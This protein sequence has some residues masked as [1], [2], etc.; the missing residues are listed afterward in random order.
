ME[1]LS[2]LGNED[3]AGGIGG[4]EPM[5]PGRL[6]AAASSAE[7]A[8]GDNALLWDRGVSETLLMLLLAPP[9]LPAVASSSLIA[10]GA[11]KGREDGKGEGLAAACTP[12]IAPGGAEAL[13]AE[14]AEGR[15]ALDPPLWLPAAAETALGA[16]AAA[17]FPA[18]KAL[19]AADVD[20]EADASAG[21]GSLAD[22]RPGLASCCRSE[23]SRFCREGFMLAPARAAACRRD[24][25]ARRGASIFNSE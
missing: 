10:V 1:T 22:R 12:T 2:G 9:P 15:P 4:K 13:S 7:M 3:E 11:G 19:A 5:S 17:A 18:A 6:A 23:G 16:A 20:D 25:G 14:E 24:V 21:V 8:A